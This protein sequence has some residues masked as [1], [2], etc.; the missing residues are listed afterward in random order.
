MALA[1]FRGGCRW[2]SLREKDLSA[3][4]R[5]DLLRRLVAL[6]RAHGA[7]VMV[8][9]DV[10]AAR[11]AGAAGVHLPEGASPAAARDVLGAGSLIGLSTHD[12][13]GLARAA[14]ERADYV[15]VSPVFPPT[16]KALQGAPL[17]TAGLARAVAASRVPVLALGG[18]GA[19]QVGVCLAAGAVGIAVI[20]AVLGADDPRAATA[21]LVERLGFAR[22]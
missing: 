5:L 19:G 10:A 20:G 14:A 22:G 15:T 1:A 2:I 13:A 11:A 18:I 8:H 21:E 7:A 17:G 4:E 16:G 12:A 9:E 6:G 3:G